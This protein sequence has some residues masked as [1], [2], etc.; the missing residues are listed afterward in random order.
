MKKLIILAAVFALFAGPAALACGASKTMAGNTVKM[1]TIPGVE[2][3]VTNLENGVRI[4]MVG[5]NA[6]AVKAVQQKMGGCPKAA[7]D[8]WAKG[9]CTGCP[10]AGQADWTRTVENT[11]N[12]VVLTVTTT[13]TDDVSKIQSIASTYGLETVTAQQAAKRG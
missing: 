4:Q 10:F 13:K 1:K 12:G 2:R 3:T 7:A 9:D 5:M 8:R 6:E 11:E